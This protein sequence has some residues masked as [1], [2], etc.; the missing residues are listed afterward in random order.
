MREIAEA[1][2]RGDKE[3]A[4]LLAREQYPFL[5]RERLQRNYAESI[6]LTLF[7]RDGFIDRYSGA[8]LY[9]PGF[10]RLMHH[11]LPDEF[12]F[13]R[14]GKA[15]RCHDIFWDLMPSVD[16]ITSIYHGGTNELENLVTTSMRRNL[17]KQ[18]STLEQLG[19]TLHPP[20]DLD[21]WSGLSKEFIQLCDQYRLHDAYVRRWCRLTRAALQQLN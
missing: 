8:R 6:K 10:L 19:W 17:A 1:L 12:P 21:E 2:I 11:L 5:V 4:Q 14:N 13:H 9:N 15:G 20:G 18:N 16:H 7:F 3:E